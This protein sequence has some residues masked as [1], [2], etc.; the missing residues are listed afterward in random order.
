MI[1]QRPCF[2]LSFYLKVLFEIEIEI[3]VWIYLCSYFGRRKMLAIT[4][5][6]SIVFELLVIIEQKAHKSSMK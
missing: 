5:F 4:S 2:D 6:Q 3:E 1:K